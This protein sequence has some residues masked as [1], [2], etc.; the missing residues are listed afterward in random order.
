MKIRPD[1]I[2]SAPLAAA[3]A[4]VP[5]AAGPLRSMAIDELVL[6]GYPR[7]SRWGIADSCQAELQR[8]MAE[9]SLPTQDLAERPQLDAAAL[10]LHPEAPPQHIGVELAQS[11]FAALVRDPRHTP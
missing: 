8:L 1:T 6:H 11:L 10:R 3:P 2:R 7:A 5:Q 4:T 9:G